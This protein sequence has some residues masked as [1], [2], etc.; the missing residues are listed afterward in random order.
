MPK[1]QTSCPQCR[2][3]LI[4]DVH[5]I[6]DVK[7]TPQLKELL[8]SGM[9][10]IAQCQLCGFQGQIPVPIVYHDP[11]KELLLSF[12]PPDPNKSMEEKESELAP[13][14]K[15]ITDNLKP[16]E[17]KGYLFQPQAM[18][19]MNNLVKNVL[20]SDGITEE[21]I[22]DQQKKL[23]L[24]DKL[25][26][27]DGDKLKEMIKENNSEIDRE[28]FTLFAEI[29]QRLLAGQDESTAQKIQEVQKALLEESDVGR[30]ILKESEEIQA[31]RASLEALGDK[32][33]RETLLGL[34]MEAPT[35]ERL[36]AYANLVR[37]AMDYEFFQLFTEKIEGTS[38]E[39]R[40]SLIDKRNLLL[41]ITQEI[42][43]RLEESFAEAVKTINEIVDSDQPEQELLKRL[44]EI[45]QVF[46]Q[47]LS[48]ELE[49]AEKGAETERKSKLEDLLHQIQE[50]TTPPELK[51][52]DILLEKADNE[53]E[54]EKALNDNQDKISPRL[55]DY[56]T[57]II[58]QYENQ[59]SNS[60]GSEKEELLQ[61]KV[62]LETVFNAVLKKSMKMKLS[63][64]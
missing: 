11:E 62:E 16:E 41:K 57:S 13:L 28:F 64:E 15:N 59:I 47:A 39:N 24:L 23:E 56:L 18:L 45:D 54:L 49:K 61:Q 44:E 25:F 38:D 5:Q 43:Q 46:I 19:T 6:I 8:L 30:V 17:R 4:A 21:M 34:V 40:T 31:A 14:L 53:Q 35:E 48:S 9:L 33:T 32:L 29:A 51:I 55:L 7:R 2:Q 50:I 22:Q 27:S 60:Q 12:I 36:K 52:L 58:N 42:D 1:I 10:N 20:K 37:P 3:P 63:G 26:T